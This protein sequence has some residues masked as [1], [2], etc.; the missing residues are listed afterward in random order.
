MTERPGGRVAVVDD[1][2]TWLKDFYASDRDKLSKYS[3]EFGAT[4]WIEPHQKL[5]VDPLTYSADV[6]E[7]KLYPL[8]KMVEI[9]NHHLDKSPRQFFGDFHAHP[10]TATWAGQ[11]PSP[12]DLFSVSTSADH[13]ELKQQVDGKDSLPI[14]PYLQLILLLKFGDIIIIEQI[15]GRTPYA[16]VKIQKGDL[17]LR[18]KDYRKWHRD[19]DRRLGNLDPRISHGEYRKT[20]ES[21]I[22]EI[23]GIVAGRSTLRLA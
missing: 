4:L 7:V 15:A 11:F 16:D 19:A 8:A 23:N 6:N 5:V 20:C 1:A 12:T 21:A 22:A 10:A 18:E 13:W 14:A 17:A 2:I 3:R 9:L